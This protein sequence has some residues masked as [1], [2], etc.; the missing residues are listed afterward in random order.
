MYYSYENKIGGPLTYINTII[1]S[2]LKKEHKFFTLFQNKAPGGLDISLLK[3]MIMEIKRIK[4]DIVHVHGAQSEGFY[5]VLAAKLA[6][7]C[8]IVTT[9]HGFAFDDSS[10]KGLSCAG[11][12]DTDPRQRPAT[13]AARHSAAAIR[14]RRVILSV[15]IP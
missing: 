8:K 10:C 9:V 11:V 5:G 15:F 4:P 6:G 14:N 1:N 7:K 2:E 13:A 12:N 3:K